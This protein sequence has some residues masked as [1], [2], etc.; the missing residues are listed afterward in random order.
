MRVPDGA[1]SGD[2]TRR[3]QVLEM[4]ILSL[5]SGSVRVGRDLHRRFVRELDE[6]GSKCKSLEARLD[7][8]AVALGQARQAAD[9][10]SAQ[11]D[12]IYSSRTWRV[13]RAMLWA[14]RAL[15]R[16]ALR[17]ESKRDKAPR[18]S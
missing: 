10:Y 13:G 18:S 7:E 11:L 14:P 12:A 16:L 5:R 1:G 9:R 17:L 2:V 3:V 8:S 15:R 4:E 6:L